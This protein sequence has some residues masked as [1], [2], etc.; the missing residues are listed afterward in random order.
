MPQKIIAVAAAHDEK[1]AVL[2]TNELVSEK[3]PSTV[4][5][6]ALVAVAKKG[7]LP[8]CIIEGPMVMDVALSKEAAMHKGIAK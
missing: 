8:R 1:V 3:M 7:E 6:A 4:D 5:A 2:A